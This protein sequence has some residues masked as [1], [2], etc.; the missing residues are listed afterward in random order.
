MDVVHPHRS[1]ALGLLSGGLDSALA[2]RLLLDQGI[3]VVGLHLESP[4][5]C[6]A[7]ARGVARELGIPL[8]VRAKGEEYLRLLRHPRW[9]Y[10][11][12]MNP[13]IDCR[14]FMFGA[15]RACRDEVGA[16]FVFTGEVVGQRPM[17]QARNTLSLIDREAGLEGWILRPLSALLLP[18]TEPE[19]RGWVDRARLLDVSG[20]GRTRQLELAARYGLRG[21]ESPGGGCLLTDPIF[22]RKLA[23]LFEHQPEERTT[24]EDVGLLRLGRHFRLEP[25]LKIVLGRSQDENR[26]LA[27][28]AGEERWLVEPV[29]FNGPTALVCGARHHGAAERAAALIARYTRDPDPAWRV[30]WR[31]DDRV[32]VEPLG[33]AALVPV[34]E[35]ADVVDPV[36][37]RTR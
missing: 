29:D 17:S 5:A 24:M 9:G 6:R 20:R 13:C 25:D 21:Y 8:E 30:R 1:R 23:D 3:E 4:T 19:K 22:A 15:A 12:N 10:G 7:D 36:A 32:R 18:E 11:R 14:V 35:P 2:A 28:F 33:G 16:H 27:A 31:Q 26:R 34:T 37:G